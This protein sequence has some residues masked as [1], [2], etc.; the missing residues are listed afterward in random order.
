MKKCRAKKKAEQMQQKQENEDLRKECARLDAENR[1]SLKNI[2]KDIEMFKQL[3]KQK[4]L[5][6]ELAKVLF[7]VNSDFESDQESD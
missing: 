3:M 4:N 7:G 6:P 5:T 1:A 2:L